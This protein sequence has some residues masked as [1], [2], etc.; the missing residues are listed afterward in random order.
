MT[1]TICHCIGHWE[2]RDNRPGWVVDVLDDGCP[3]L[4]HRAGQVA[5]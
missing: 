2:S 1:S 5:L 4:A 3:T